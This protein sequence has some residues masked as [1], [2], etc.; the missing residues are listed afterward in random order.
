MATKTKAAAKWKWP[1]ATQLLA[2]ATT[3]GIVVVA[4]APVL[5]AGPEW[6]GV[7]IA[8]GVVAVVIAKLTQSERK[9]P[10]SIAEAHDVLDK[11]GS[12]RGRS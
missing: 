2:W 1:N 5:P 11:A 7:R 4:V 9:L 8:L 3:L 10:P 12:A 6:E